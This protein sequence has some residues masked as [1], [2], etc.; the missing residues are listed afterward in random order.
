MAE[1]LTDLVSDIHT[2]HILH[3]Y[4]AWLTQYSVLR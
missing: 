1:I 3:Q 4:L 2:L